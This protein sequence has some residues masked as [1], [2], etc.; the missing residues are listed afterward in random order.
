MIRLLILHLIVFSVNSIISLRKLHDKRARCLDGSV[1]GY[2]LEKAVDPS[3]ELKWVLYL[4][5]GGECDTKEGCYSHL[6]SELGS[7]DYFKSNYSDS[8]SW[9][10]ASGYCPFNPNFCTWNHVNVPYCSQDLHSGTRKEATAETWDLFFA[11]HLIIESILDELDHMGLEKATDI[12]LTGVSAGGLGTYMNIDYIKDRY[13]NARVTAATI[14]GYYFYATYYEGTNHTNPEDNIADFTADGMVNLYELHQSY[15]DES[16]AKAM[17]SSNIHPSA[18]MMANYSLPY[19]KSDIFAVQS[20]TDKVVLTGHDCLPDDYKM[21]QEEQDFMKLW[22]QNMSIALQPVLENSSQSTLDI[23]TG[24]FAA[25][26]YIHGEFSHDQPL[27]DGM[28][29]IQAFSSFY[30]YSTE[31]DESSYKLTDDCGIMCNP[32]CPPTT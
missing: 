8:S 18:C 14:A 19:L 27:I 21:E 5:G 4:N 7:S 11:G 17:K 15:V 16:C 2:Y 25:A 32:T 9:Y 13:P 3:T 30:Y 23:R 22:Y 26:C 1:S 29:Y 10:F 12:I 20:L 24:A 31:S 28:S 6:Q